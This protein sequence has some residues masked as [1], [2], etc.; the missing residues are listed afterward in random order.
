[1][2]SVGTQI[3]FKRRI[4]QEACG[5]HPELLMCNKDDIGVVVRH[6]NPQENRD[7]IYTVLNHNWPRAI[8][9]CNENEF[10]VLSEQV[11]G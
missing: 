3:R 9:L 11:Q 1:M 5:D 4:T 8:F 2:I 6:L 10:E 7:F